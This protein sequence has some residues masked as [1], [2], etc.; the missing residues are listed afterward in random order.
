MEVYLFYFIL[1]NISETERRKIKM[2]NYHRIDTCNVTDGPG[3]R[4]VIWFSGCPFHCKGC[5]QPETWHPK[6]GQLYDK[7]AREEMIKALEEPY[8]RRERR[9]P[10]L[11]AA[12]HTISV[13]TLP[14]APVWW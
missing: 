11:A 6:S 5:F 12:Y 2:A 8:S 4:A 14:T 9:Y 7:Q 1:Y 10:T 13:E 3:C